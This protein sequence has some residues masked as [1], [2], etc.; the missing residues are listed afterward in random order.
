M[1]ELDLNLTP[2][3]STKFCK[4]FDQPAIV[5]FCRIEIRMDKRAAIR[6]TPTIGEAWVFPTPELKSSLLLVIRS[7]EQSIFGN[8]GRFEVIRQCDNQMNAATG[9]AP[10]NSLPR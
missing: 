8:N 10:H 9:R 5:L 3:Q 2:T 7:M 4:T 1:V 6:V